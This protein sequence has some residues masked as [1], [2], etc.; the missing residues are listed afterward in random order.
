MG[1]GSSRCGERWCRGVPVHRLRHP[2][3]PQTV[4]GIRTVDIFS[5]RRRVENILSAADEIEHAAEIRNSGCAV[6]DNIHAPVIAGID[7]CENIVVQNTV[8]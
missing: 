6:P 5:A 7:P 2:D 4:H 3:T 8:R 1:A